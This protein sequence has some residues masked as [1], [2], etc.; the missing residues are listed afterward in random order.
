MITFKYATM[1]PYAVHLDYEQ[2]HKIFAGYADRA[3]QATNGNRSAWGL[4]WT[5]TT[6]TVAFKRKRDWDQFAQIFKPRSTTGSASAGT[7][8]SNS[9]RNAATG[10]QPR[11]DAMPTYMLAFDHL[12]PEQVG[13]LGAGMS[14]VADDVVG[15]DRSIYEMW[16]HDNEIHVGFKHEEDRDDFADIIDQEADAAVE[17]IGLPR[18]AGAALP[19]ITVH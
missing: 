11:R 13:E 14:E 18:Q 19:Q 12:H 15:D 5:G 1:L 10:N 7:H 16:F 17:I 4:R 6:L 3:D 2:I 9:E 8:H